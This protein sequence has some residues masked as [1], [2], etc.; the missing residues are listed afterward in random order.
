M[1]NQV[2]HMDGNPLRQLSKETLQSHSMQGLQ[3]V[4]LSQCKIQKVSEETFRSCLHLTH[5]NLAN[6]N[7][8]KIPPGLFTG[9]DALQTIILSGN[10][11]AML[12]AYQF[13][14]LLSLRKIDLSSNG[15][16]MIDSKAFM[17]LGSSMEVVDLRGNILRTMAR[18][19]FFPLHQLKVQNE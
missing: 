19:T 5:V 9:N 8:T 12:V 11:L 17:N 2:L 1:M 7:L 18:E 10:Q 16:R 13:P 14:P 15:M 3:E 6:N 4:S